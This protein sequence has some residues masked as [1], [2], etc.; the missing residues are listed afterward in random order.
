MK[1]WLPGAVKLDL[2]L[3]LPQMKIWLPGAVKLDLKLSIS[4]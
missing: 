3:S 2:K 4:G 1:I